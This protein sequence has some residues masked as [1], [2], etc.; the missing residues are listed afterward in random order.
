MGL[1]IKSSKNKALKSMDF[2]K[3]DFR[4]KVLKPVAAQLSKVPVHGYKAAHV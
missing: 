4:F 2:F 1:K 3:F